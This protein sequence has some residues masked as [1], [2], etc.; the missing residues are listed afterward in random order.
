MRTRQQLRVSLREID[1]V[2]AAL[3]EHAI[4][5]KWDT[6]P[7]FADRQREKAARHQPIQGMR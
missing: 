4:E 2:K 1:G 7:C 3:E 6:V 5:R